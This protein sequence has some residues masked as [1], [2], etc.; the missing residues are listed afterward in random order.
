MLS[1]IFACLRIIFELLLS[2]ERVRAIGQSTETQMRSIVSVPT[3]YL[4]ELSSTRMKLIKLSIDL[5]T[6]F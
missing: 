2:D 3:I 5:K 4:N 6:N 1:G